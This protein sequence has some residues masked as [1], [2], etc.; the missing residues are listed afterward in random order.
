M[1]GLYQIAAETVRASEIKLGDTV[2]LNDD[3]FRP[4]TYEV[5]AITEHDIDLEFRLVDIEADRLRTIY[6]L[7][8]QTL[9]R[10]SS[11]NDQPEP[12]VITIV[13]EEIRAGD[14]L[15]DT[16]GD[17]YRVNSAERYGDRI[18]LGLQDDDSYERWLYVAGDKPQSV[19]RSL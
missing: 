18:R 14:Y 8:Q 11:A 10:T 1:F 7:R 15:R 3:A 13:A 2:V 17:F 5:A 6:R 9:R 16:G 12:A 4:C 19:M